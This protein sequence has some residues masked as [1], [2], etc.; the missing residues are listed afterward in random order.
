MSKT[1]YITSSKKTKATKAHNYCLVGSKITLS[2]RS[3]FVVT[4][5]IV[6]CFISFY[7]LLLMSYQSIPFVIDVQ[8][9]KC[10]LK[11]FIF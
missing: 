5:I 9:S 4:I 10:V 6:I 1:T 3:I 7:F 8:G 11:Y 2:L